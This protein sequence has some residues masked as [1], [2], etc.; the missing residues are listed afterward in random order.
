MASNLV[1]GMDVNCLVSSH[2]DVH[3]KYFFP[4]LTIS[5]F[6]L[7]SYNIKNL[8]WLQL[9]YN[10]NIWR[11]Q[12]WSPMLKLRNSQIGRCIQRRGECSRKSGSGLAEGNL[13][14][15]WDRCGK[16]FSHTLKARDPLLILSSCNLRHQ[17]KEG[18]LLDSL[19]KEASPWAGNVPVFN[20]ERSKLLEFGFWNPV[21]LR[22]RIRYA[23]G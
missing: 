7:C 17:N 22:Y 21:P 19:F 23:T 16:R 10:G 6:C 13:D 1:A 8:T 3:C 14:L 2:L 11:S 15:W 4:S 12:M 9:T 18:I 20:F 5:L